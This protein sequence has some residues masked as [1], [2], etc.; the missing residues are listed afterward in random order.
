MATDTWA[1]EHAINWLRKKGFKKIE[2]INSPVDFSASKNGVEYWI[3]LK[4]TKSE[5][6]AF[7][8]VTMTEWMCAIDNPDRFYFLVVSKPG[9][10][11]KQSDWNI[12]LI[13]PKELIQYS[14]ISPFKINFQL[15]LDEP[16]NLPK[17]RKTTIVPTF[18]KIRQI[19]EFYSTLKNPPKPNLF[20][21][22]D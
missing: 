21:L 4:A 8:N 10:I 1:R 12:K 19:D 3:E 14:Y 22:R 7:G 2:K 11:D 17:R 9:G 16:R 6:K 18:A 13:T 20:D 5:K 15:P